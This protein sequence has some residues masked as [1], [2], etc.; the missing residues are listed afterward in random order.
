MKTPI[1]NVKRKRPGNGNITRRLLQASKEH[2][3]K[4]F[5]VLS[6]L[7]QVIIVSIHKNADKSER[8]YYR[9]ITLSVAD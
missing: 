5:E 2:V 6:D 1:E 4:A 9:E 7:G 8:K 3:V